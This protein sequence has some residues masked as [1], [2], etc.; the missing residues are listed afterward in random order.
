MAHNAL[1]GW[2]PSGTT[3]QTGERELKI[4]QASDMPC[5]DQEDLFYAPDGCDGR[6][7]PGR[8]S[9]ES[10]ARSLCEGCPIQL[11]CLY[12]SLVTH[13]RWGVWGGLGEGDRR[14]FL[15]QLR[16]E[17]YDVDHGDFPE[18]GRELTSAINEFYEHNATG[19]ERYMGLAS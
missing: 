11:K 5:S 3:H 4:I 7:E 1:D 13:E 6:S 14:K 10:A 16:D 17:G 9:R 12:T 19:L 15:D 8:V 18:L 2:P